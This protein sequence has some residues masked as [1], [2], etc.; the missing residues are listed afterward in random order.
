MC[1]RSKAL[2]ELINSEK[3]CDIKFGIKFA[4]TNVGYSKKIFT[5]PHF[6]EFEV[7]EFLKNAEDLL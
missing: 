4:D 1:N 7:T 5:F 6:T 2:R 3:Y